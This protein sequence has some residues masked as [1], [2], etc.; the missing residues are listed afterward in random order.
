MDILKLI[1]KDHKETAKGLAE[2]EETEENDAAARKKIWIPLEEDLLAHMKAEEEI[3]YPPLKEE[4]EDKILEAIEE[5]QLLRMA[6]SVLDETPAN[7][8][9]WL[10]KLKVI[11]ENIEHHVEEEE[12]EIFEAARK[13]LSKE[14]LEEL[15]KRFEEAKGKKTSSK[16]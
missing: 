1:E 2:L 10:P 5:H 13:K 12:D 8:K 16:K 11:K 14:K 3:L 4:I 6:S 9:T 15:G 7:D